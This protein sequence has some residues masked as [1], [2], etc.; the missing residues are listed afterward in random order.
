MEDYMRPY[1]KTYSNGGQTICGKHNRLM[2]ICSNIEQN[3]STNNHDYQSILDDISEMQEILSM[4]K[5]D[6]MNMEKALE[7]KNES[8]HDL[9]KESGFLQKENSDLQERISM[10]EDEIKNLESE[11][12]NV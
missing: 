8:I 5:S 2:D 1:N 12:Q 7:R 6:G 10:L 9:E 4:A 3:L 11:L